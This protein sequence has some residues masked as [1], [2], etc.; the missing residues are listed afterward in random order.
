MAK[1]IAAAP[2]PAPQPP[3][4]GVHI[5]VAIDDPEPEDAKAGKSAVLPAIKMGATD[6]YRRLADSA[7]DAAGRTAE[8]AAEDGLTRGEARAALSM[9]GYVKE[10]AA[11]AAA[12]AS[13]RTTTTPAV[14]LQ[15][16]SL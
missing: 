9:L 4:E 6:A 13:T 12:A 8:S 11:A 15:L 5:I 7:F 14:L 2:L 3:T 10:D 1:P 16:L